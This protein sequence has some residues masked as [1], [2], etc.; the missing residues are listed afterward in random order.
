MRRAQSGSNVRHLAKGESI[1][2]LPKLKSRGPHLCQDG[3]LRVF[4]SIAQAQAAADRTLGQAYKSKVT[5][6]YLV[7][8]D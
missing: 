7:R 3:Y 1:E 5:G 4:E 6:A 8:F 2:I